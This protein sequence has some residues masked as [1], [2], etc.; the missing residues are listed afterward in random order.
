MQHENLAIKPL[1][2]NQH[3]KHPKWIEM[4]LSH[5]FEKVK[6]GWSVRTVFHAAQVGT[7]ALLASAILCKR[8][9]LSFLAL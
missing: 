7:G 6:I 2:N 8:V 9:P 4:G 1:K 5:Q 3:I